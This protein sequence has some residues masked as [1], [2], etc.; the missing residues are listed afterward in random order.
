MVGALR[1]QAAAVLPQLLTQD[2][3]VLV[4]AEGPAVW[5]PTT[6]QH[7]PV[8]PVSTPVK[9]SLQPVRSVRQSGLVPITAGVEGEPPAF[10]A[11]LPRAA[12]PGGRLAALQHS[13]REF[14]PVGEPDDVGGLNVYWQVALAAPRAIAT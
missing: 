13:G 4:P 9:G 5:N 1:A 8:A 10:V 6:E 3:T 14:A 12:L 11:Y 2:L 7:D